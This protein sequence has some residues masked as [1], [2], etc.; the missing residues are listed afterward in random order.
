MTSIFSAAQIKAWDQYTIMHEPIT[1]IDL[2]ERAARACVAWLMTRWPSTE[3]HFLIF[4]GNGNNGGDGLA[5][6]R[7][8]LEN[9]YHVDVYLSDKLPRSDDNKVNLTEL[10]FLHKSCI[11]VFEKPIKINQHAVVIDAIYGTGLNKSVE[12]VDQSMVQTINLCPNTVV[13]IDIPS[14]LSPDSVLPEGDI[15]EADYTLTFQQPKRSFLSPE[16]GGYCGKV[17]VLDIRLHPG[18]ALQETTTQFM[19][20][21]ELIR[22]LYKR[23][24]AFSH[25][26]TY[27]HAL[28]VCGSLGKMGAAVLSAKAC[29]R[30]GAGLVTAYLP[31]SENAI[32]QMAVP[33]AMTEPMIDLKVLLG[34]KKFDAIGL[35]CG[36]GTQGYGSTVVD[37]VLTMAKGPLL[38]DAD[39]LNILSIEK[40]WMDRIPKGSVLTPHPTEFDRLF[41]VSRNSFD[42]NN[43][44]IGMSKRYGIYIV[45]KGCYTAVSTPEGL[46]YFNPTGNPG[47]ATG[48]SG[49]VLSGLITGLFAQY[50]D[51][52]TA[53]L[54]GVYLHGLAGDLA[55]Q[56]MSQESM[57]ASDLIT[58]MGKAFLKTFYQGNMDV[59]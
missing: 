8:L 41:G 33:E 10:E 39:A 38:L 57:T 6:A 22:S 34:N 18:F 28:L 12:G 42:R 21:E 19:M 32:M 17:L 50:Q 55:A 30:S 54:M 53:A 58:Y 26:G 2:M 44:Q 56:D 43:L 13:S 52:K 51:M 9:A 15:V 35:G 45:L 40:K 59:A 49:D 20:D 25:K 14:G 47:M 3:T 5:I 4:C 37:R 36:I 27:G 29:V 24:A 48:G 16:S 1:S 31:A 46:C 7:I 23:R 11:H